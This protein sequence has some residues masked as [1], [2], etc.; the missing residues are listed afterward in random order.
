[1]ENSETQVWLDFCLA[2]AYIDNNEK[3]E[4]DE[5]S[6]EV[7]KMLH[8]MI[9]SPQKFSIDRNRERV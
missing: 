8:S 3:T 4:M 9:A 2:C 6:E 1:M 7:G 5:I